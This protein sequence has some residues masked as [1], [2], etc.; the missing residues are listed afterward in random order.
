MFSYCF[1]TEI[2]NFC[3]TCKRRKI[4]GTSDRV[5]MKR[6]RVQIEYEKTICL[7]DCTKHAGSE[8]F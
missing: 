1:E 7:T 2:F 8:M 5:T 6:V 4:G 3:T